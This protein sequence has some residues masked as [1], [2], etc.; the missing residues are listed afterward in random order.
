MNNTNKNKKNLVLGFVKT[1][2]FEQIKPFVI[3][4][5]NTGYQGDICLVYCDLSQR[6]IDL[7]QE[8]GVQMY[9]F[10]EFYINL[11]YYIGQ[12]G[13]LKQNKKIYPYLLL[14]IYPFNRL[15]TW[16]LRGA[17]KLAKENEDLIKAHVA[18]YFLNVPSCN[19]YAIYYLYLSK[20]GEKYANVMLS[21]VRDVVFQGD[22]FD[23]E[24]EDGSLNCFLEE[25]EKTIGDSEGNA[26]WIR[27]GFGED[28][29]PKIADK[30]ISCSGTTIGSIDA[31]MAY[32]KAMIDAFVQLK[33]HS[34]GIDQGVHN[35]IIYQGLVKKVKFYNNFR[36]P[37]LTMHYTNEEKLQ[38]DSNGY[39][40]NDD[41]SPI[42]VLHQYDRL[43]PEVR[44][45]IAVYRKSECTV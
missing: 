22:P 15:Y 42:K 8:Q 45:K 21:D 11:P 29:L 2:E 34:W 36:G 9:P 18:Q 30:S 32:L 31:I 27:E 23:F 41:G 20:Y 1:Y 12:G 24:F 33:Y 35:Y 40:R 17:S 25:G 19:R 6:T 13:K 14:N 10:K 3:S 43:S 5:K 39:L 4:L 26:Q 16:L 38:F 28:A 37:I 7:L 44:N